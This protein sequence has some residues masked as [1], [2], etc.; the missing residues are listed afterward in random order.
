MKKTNMREIL[1]QKENMKKP[2]MR[3]I[4]KQNWEYEKTNMRK[5]MDK[6]N[7]KCL[8]KTEKSCQQIR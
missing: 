1:K 3:K 8:N 4:L 7:K 5:K 2:K 6:E